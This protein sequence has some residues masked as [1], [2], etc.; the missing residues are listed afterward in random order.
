MQKNAWNL[1][2]LVLVCHPDFSQHHCLVGALFKL[3]LFF[4][5][6]QHKVWGLQTYKI[7]SEMAFPY[8]LAPFLSLSFG[9][10][11]KDISSLGAEAEATDVAP[12]LGHGQTVLHCGHWLRN[13][14]KNLNTKRICGEKGLV[15]CRNPLLPSPPCSFTWEDFPFP[16]LF[17]LF[18]YRSPPL[19]NRLKTG[20]VPPQAWNLINFDLPG[21]SHSDAWEHISWPVLEIFAHLSTCGQDSRQGCGNPDPFP[22]FSSDFSSGSHIGLPQPEGLI[23]QDPLA[24]L[25]L[26][27]HL[28]II[29]PLAGWMWL[30][31]IVGLDHN[32]QTLFL[33][34]V[35]NI[36]RRSTLNTTVKEL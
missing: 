1:Q 9:L 6:D 30:A 13:G 7:T 26:S 19:L 14:A 5:P 12:Q 4:V 20:P 11:C 22:Q 27:M 8:H 24:T 31:E 18:L 34:L 3:S 28:I 32:T 33:E 35:V 10:N 23:A 16:F 21:P 2:V 15:D 29:L 36:Y 25:C 17:F